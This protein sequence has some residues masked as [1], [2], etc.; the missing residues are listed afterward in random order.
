M[1]AIHRVGIAAGIVL[2]LLV[3]AVTFEVVR[4]RFN[5][6]PRVVSE[7]NLSTYEKVI[8][9]LGTPDH[10][11]VLTSVT[12]LQSGAFGVRLPEPLRSGARTVPVRASMWNRRC[13]CVAEHRF[14]VFSSPAGSVIFVGG[15]SRNTFPMFVSSDFPETQ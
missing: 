2:V 1:R 5:A 11:T 7:A 6:L 12:E 13:F 9:Q 3:L 14:V 4:C 10:E 8:E 15:Y